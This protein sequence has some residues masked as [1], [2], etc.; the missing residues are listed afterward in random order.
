MNNEL[1]SCPFCGGKGVIKAV[2]KNYGL[3]IWC[4]CKKNDEDS[5]YGA[6]VTM[7]FSA[8][9]CGGLYALLFH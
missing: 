1:K 4:Q 5:F 7:A 8:L 9:I 2:N 3:T 6:F